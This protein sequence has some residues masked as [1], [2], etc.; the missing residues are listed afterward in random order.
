M[1]M[2]PDRWLSHNGLYGYLYIERGSMRQLKIGGLSCFRPEEGGFTN[3]QYG[4]VSHHRARHD[5]I[6]R[7]TLTIYARKGRLPPKNGLSD[8]AST[9]RYLQ[10]SNKYT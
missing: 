4:H 2:N 8:D 1:E 10:R 7:G 6:L 3:T 5:P 9:K